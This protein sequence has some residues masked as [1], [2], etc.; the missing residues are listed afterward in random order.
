M[1]L[2][3][4]RVVAEHFDDDGVFPNS[5]LPLLIYHRGLESDGVSPEALEGL[6]SANGWAPRWRDS[7]YPFHHFHSN[8]HECIGIASGEARLMLGGPQGRKFDVALGD[9]LLIPAGVAHRR[10][11]AS[12]DFLAVG[13][14]PPGPEW[15]LLRG[16]AGERPKA[17]QTI[18]AVVLP[19]SDPVEGKDG[20]LMQWWR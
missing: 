13:A 17:D 11:D 9:V 19:E 16:E 7:I 15:D 20:T 18:A 8:A 12:S 3:G 4:R 10:I 6:F 5:K 14:Y 2:H 1:S